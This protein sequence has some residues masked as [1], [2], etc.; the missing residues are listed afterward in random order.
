MG[1]EAGSTT[2]DIA[3]YIKNQLGIEPL[4][5]ATCVN[6][7]EAELMA[8]LRALEANNVENILALRG[9]LPGGQPLE[10]SCIHASDLAALI[11]R[12]SSVNLVGACYPEGHAETHDLAEDISN[13]HYKLDAGVKHLITQLF[14]DNTKFY[15]F[16]EK[17]RAAGITVP[18]EAGI[19]P[20]VT[21]RQIERT[22]ALS[23]ASLPAD[24][25]RMVS[26]YSKNPEALYHAGIAYAI[27]QICV[28]LE[29]VRRASMY[30]P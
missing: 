27:D 30:T 23:G 1:G 7:T 14:F 21:T 17:L 11:S 29:T 3:S 4:A 8:N 22:I 20:I 28:L 5:H 15:T 12:S 25:T 2:C 16:M 13:L 19:M 9:D 10:G 24:F 26:R 18:V 6:A